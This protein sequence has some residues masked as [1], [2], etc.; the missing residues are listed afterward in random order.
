LASLRGRPVV[1]CFWQKNSMPAQALRRI[2]DLH[3]RVR[4]SEAK[5]ILIHA[6]EPAGLAAV[7]RFLSESVRG[8]A[9]VDGLE[10]DMVKW[11]FPCGIDRP[12]RSGAQYSAG[13]PLGQSQEPYGRVACPTFV[14]I[15]RDGKVAADSHMCAAEWQAALAGLRTSGSGAR[16][17]NKQP[18][19][20]GAVP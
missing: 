17:A 15:D 19:A 16:P 18:R 7:R 2:F 1:L 3:A 6:P 11:P 13:F 4:G 10:L 8:D 9:L 5:V 20:A 12:A 14:L